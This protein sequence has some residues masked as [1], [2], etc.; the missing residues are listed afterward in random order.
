MANVIFEHP[1][2]NKTIPTKH[3]ETFVGHVIQNPVII[4]SVK[5]SC[6]CTS[7]DYPKTELISRFEIKLTLDLQPGFFSKN[8]VITFNNGETHTLTISGKAE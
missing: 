4:S 6:G 8:A 5:V 2:I 1:T 3:S 7:V